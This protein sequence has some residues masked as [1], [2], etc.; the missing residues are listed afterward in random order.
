VGEAFTLGRWI[1]IAIVV[2]LVVAAIP[3]FRRRQRII[4]AHS[5]EMQS[6]AEAHDCNYVNEDSNQYAG[7]TFYPFGQT[8][9][10]FAHRVITG[11]YATR[12]IAVYD[13]ISSNGVER[14]ASDDIQ[15]AM[16]VMQVATG[17][18]WLHVTERKNLQPK[19]EADAI[20]TGDEVFDTTY[21]LFA[22][23]QQ[24]AKSAVSATV[25]AGLPG[26][27]LSGMHIVDGRL[28][29]WQ[30]RHQHDVALLEDRLRFAATVAAELPVPR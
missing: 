29:L 26:Q 30:T 22:T 28:F 17:V 13:F 25:R 21:A 11:K 10:Q 12:T 24:Y 9:R 27:S 19:V 16:I 15:F 18:P 8:S 20:S 4:D 5:D 14:S 6:W 2:V 3:L 7:Y 1:A 23:D